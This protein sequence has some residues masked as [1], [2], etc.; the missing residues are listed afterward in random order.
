ML[1]RI[2]FIIV[3][4]SLFV[5]LIPTPSLWSRSPDTS[6]NVEQINN[7]HQTI[8]EENTPLKSAKADI[9]TLRKDLPEV[10][11]RIKSASSQKAYETNKLFI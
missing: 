7:N 10:K 2:A 11:E 5:G 1:P 9:S 6:A 4:V 3:S 8:P